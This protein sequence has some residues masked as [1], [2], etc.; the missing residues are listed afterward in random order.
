[1]ET[2]CKG[3]ASEK[4]DAAVFQRAVHDCP[5]CGAELL[6]S[7]SHC[8][9]CQKNSTDLD[10]LLGTEGPTLRRFMDFQHHLEGAEKKVKNA[11]SKIERKFPQLTLLYCSVN[12]PG[13]LKPSHLAWWM[14]N[15]GEHSADSSWTGLLL[16]DSEKRQ[17][18]F[19]SGYELETFIPRTEL[20]FLLQECG[21]W[22]AIGEW[23]GGVA[24]FFI[25][26]YPI[27]VRAHQVALKTKGR[28]RKQIPKR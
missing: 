25:E 26:L 10:R 23:A 17:I 21:E 9:R 15:Q 3:Q 8:S 12:C 11:I 16:L 20:E 27:L 18:T 5:F 13:E 28:A 7:P 2:N 19:Q 14:F 1:M 24:N 6:E 4:P 22:F